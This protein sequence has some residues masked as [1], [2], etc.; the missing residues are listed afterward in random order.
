MSKIESQEPR[1]RYCLRLLLNIVI[2]ASGWILALFA[3]PWLLKFFMPFVI[4]LVIAL[5]AKPLVRFLERRLRLV[6]RHSSLLIVAA[7]L[8]LVIGLIYLVISRTVR[9][10][11]SFA[12]YLPQLYETAEAAV[13]QGLE[14]LGGS[15]DFLPQSLRESWEALGSSL[16]DY[17]GLAV[18]KAAPPTVEAAGSVARVIPALLVYSVVTVLSA[19]FFIVER[20]RIAAFLR[21]HLPAGALRYQEYLKGELKRLVC[22]YFLA[23]LKIMGVVWLILTAG[24]FVLG[25]GYAP[26]WALLI[27]LLD[28]L[29]VFGTGTVLI[30]W[31]IIVVLDGEYAFAAGLLLLYVLTQV[32]RQAV[33]PKLVGDS[34]GLNPFLTLLF[35][36]LGFKAGGIAGMILAVPVGLFFLNL[37]HFGAFKGTTDSA[38]ALIQEI[39]AFRKGEDKHE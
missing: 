4:G 21:E 24:F 34:M 12:E 38:A 2:P 26:L 7:V 36:Y 29:P 27:S 23:Q 1:W 18:E 32:T 25:V 13:R 15:M 10:A 9:A 11:R 19:Y 33:Q 20:D 6:R 37:Y 35:L 16:G 17:L 39:Q 5:I 3:G 8:A 14:R 31:G 30:P 22:G 28:F